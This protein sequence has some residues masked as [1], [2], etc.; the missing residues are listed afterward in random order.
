MQQR[1]LRSKRLLCNKRFFF[2]FVSLLKLSRRLLC[3]VRF[4]FVSTFNLQRGRAFFVG[5]TSLSKEAV[6]VHLFE[7]RC[8]FLIHFYF[9]ITIFICWALYFSS[10]FT[11]LRLFPFYLLGW[12]KI[13]YLKLTVSLITVF[14]PVE[15]QRSL[16]SRLCDCPASVYC[17]CDSCH[18]LEAWEGPWGEAE[19][20]YSVVY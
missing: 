10:F 19:D 15:N 8:K 17:W 12:R 16:F 18:L 20:L 1:Q 11:S 4:I 5:I 3:S 13:R 2:A 14:C 7:S 9:R 6:C